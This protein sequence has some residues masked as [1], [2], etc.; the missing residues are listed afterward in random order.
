MLI[1]V[2]CCI[3]HGNDIV[4]DRQVYDDQLVID[5]RGS[6]QDCGCADFVQYPSLG[7]SESSIDSEDSRNLAGEEETSQGR[8]PDTVPVDKF[9]F[10]I[11]DSVLSTNVGSSPRSRVKAREKN[12]LRKWRGMV[13]AGGTDWSSYLHRY[14]AKVKRRIRKGI[15]DALRGLVWQLLSGMQVVL[16]LGPRLSWSPIF[17]AH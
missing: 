1:V 8:P 11:P 14:P 10:V 13:G 4:D 15:P 16:T 5:S 2:R 6:E 9:G 7:T 3:G 17:R 12:R